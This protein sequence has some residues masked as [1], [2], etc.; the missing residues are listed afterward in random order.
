MDKGRAHLSPAF[1][2]RGFCSLAFL[3]PASCLPLI[4]FTT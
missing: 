2:L 4:Q 1:G 3:F